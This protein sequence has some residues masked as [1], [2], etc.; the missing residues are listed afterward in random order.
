MPNISPCRFS[1]FQQLYLAA[2]LRKRVFA[3]V[4]DDI[5]I[6]VKHKSIGVDIFFFYIVLGN[7]RDNKFLKSAGYDQ[8]LILV[9]LEKSGVARK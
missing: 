3:V 6:L 4:T 9:V 2:F 5:A 7:Y 1:L 8:H